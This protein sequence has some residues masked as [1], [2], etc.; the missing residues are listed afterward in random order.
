M[1]ILL[2]FLSKL[3]GQAMQ[4]VALGTKR[5]ALA[6]AAATLLALAGVALAPAVIAK[7]RHDEGHWVG[8]WSASPQAVAAPIHINGQTV[9]QIVHTSLGGDRVRVRFSNVYGTSGLVIGSTWWNR[10]TRGKTLDWFRYQR[11]LQRHPLL[12]PRICHAWASTGSP[13]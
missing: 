10:R 11:L 4:G 2:Q 1:S 7:D 12:L 8:T 5:C 13:A 3:R 9:R 6:T